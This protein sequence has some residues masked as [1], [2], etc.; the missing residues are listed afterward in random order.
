MQ[1]DEVNKSYDQ[2]EW[3]IAP[4]FMCLIL[5]HSRCEGQGL[6][7][8]KSTMPFQRQWKSTHSNEE[9]SFVVYIFL[10]VY[11]CSTLMSLDLVINFQFSVYHACFPPEVSVWSAGSDQYWQN[12]EEKRGIQVFFP[13]CFFLHICFFN[14]DRV[15]M[16]PRFFCFA[17]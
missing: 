1:H 7:M 3:I 16:M 9:M 10:D 11:D 5:T 6:I 12:N 17:L 8:Y 13:A 14:I 15:S 4:S 2:F